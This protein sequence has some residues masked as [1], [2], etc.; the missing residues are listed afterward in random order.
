MS[1]LAAIYV[2]ESN[3]F[4]HEGYETFVPPREEKEEGEISDDEGV[5][6]QQRQKEAALRAKITRKK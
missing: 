4:E 6:P 1:I 5:S 2:G 3:P